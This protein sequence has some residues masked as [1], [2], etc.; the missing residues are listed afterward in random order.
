MDEVCISERID[1]PV[2]CTRRKRS[3]R[4]QDKSLHRSLSQQHWMYARCLLPMGKDWQTYN[5]SQQGHVMSP[6]Q[7]L[8]QTFMYWLRK[9]KFKQKSL[10]RDQL[11]TNNMLYFV[12]HQAHIHMENNG[13]YFVLGYKR[14]VNAREKSRMVHRN[15]MA[16]FHWKEKK[17]KDGSVWWMRADTIIFQMF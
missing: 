6:T 7:R 2:L 13:I 9:K 16:L 3:P 5:L 17:K 8:M 12:K 11:S 14:L 15:V 4:S 1:F 10:T